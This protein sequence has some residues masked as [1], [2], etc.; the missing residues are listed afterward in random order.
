MLRVVGLKSISGELVN[1]KS[2]SKE[3][4]AV[5]CGLQLDEPNI[6]ERCRIKFHDGLM[7]SYR[8]GAFPA[9]TDE[10]N[11]GSPRRSKAY[12]PIAATATSVTT[13]ILTFDR[14]HP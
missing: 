14:A 11:I 5:N 4:S 7:S 2:A 8:T 6:T 9:A 13:A 1:A 3:A 12:C 10:L